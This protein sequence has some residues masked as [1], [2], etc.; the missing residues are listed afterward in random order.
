MTI[1][2]IVRYSDQT[3][4]V[5]CPYGTVKRVVTGGEGTANIH[6]VTVTQ[7]SEHFHHAYDEAYYF[8]SG[9]GTITLDQKTDAVRPGTIVVIPAGTIHSLSSDSE[10][11]LEF[12]IFGT[13]P[14]SIDDERAKP[15]KP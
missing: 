13:P 1:K 9:S 5:S 14:M 3:E 7:G 4:P 6:I 10:Q 8:L 12:I 11:P 2:P 15:L